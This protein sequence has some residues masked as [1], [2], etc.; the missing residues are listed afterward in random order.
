MTFCPVFVGKEDIIV[1][2]ELSKQWR[3]IPTVS[4]LPPNH[5][6][7]VTEATWH[8]QGVRCLSPP[9]EM[10]PYLVALNLRKDSFRPLQMVPSNDIQFGFC[11]S[12]LV[13]C[14]GSLLMVFFRADYGSLHAMKSHLRLQRWLKVSKGPYEFF[15][16]WCP[17]Q[18]TH[19]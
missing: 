18:S 15:Q 10:T 12:Y 16:L 17:F 2:E 7:K 9:L 5:D 11:H 6:T 13:V 3:S 8:I 19:H 14:N 1:Y 4:F